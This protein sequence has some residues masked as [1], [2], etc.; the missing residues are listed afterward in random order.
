MIW[1]HQNLINEI[2]IITVTTIAKRK[3]L[4]SFSRVI[5]SF[6]FSGSYCSNF[7]F[8][9]F[10]FLQLL[11]VAYLQTTH[12]CVILLQGTLLMQEKQ[13]AEYKKDYQAIK[14]LQ[15]QKIL[16]SV[17]YAEITAV[18]RDV[19]AGVDEHDYCTDSIFCILHISNCRQVRL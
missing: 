15:T 6:A 13:D 5:N 4:I 17:L 7:F 10:S 18:R 3:S 9:S 1:K 12:L 14:I 11:I 8:R 16:L 19:R 2:A